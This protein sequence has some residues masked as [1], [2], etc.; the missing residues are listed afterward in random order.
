MCKKKK[1]VNSVLLRIFRQV[2]FKVV[3]LLCKCNMNLARESNR[4]KK[5]SGPLK[6]SG[7]S[8]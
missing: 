2:K 8:K 5:D 7:E 4:K 6:E 3:S 1:R